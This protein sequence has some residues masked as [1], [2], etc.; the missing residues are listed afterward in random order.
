MSYGTLK[1][2]RFKKR[3]SDPILIGT[4]TL[5]RA[6]IEHLSFLEASEQDA[7]LTIVLRKKIGKDGA[8]EYPIQAM[9]EQI[10]LPPSTQDEFL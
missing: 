9:P 6:L 1:P 7:T 2:N 3:E 10:D 8:P 5:S 4:I